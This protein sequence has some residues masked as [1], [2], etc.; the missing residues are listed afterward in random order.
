MLR[1]YNIL[2]HRNA[3][4]LCVVLS[5]RRTFEG[6]TKAICPFG[7]LFAKLNAQTFFH[8]NNIIMITNPSVEAFNELLQGAEPIVVDFNATWCGPCR[9][10]APIFD[11]LDKE[12]AGRAQFVSVD[13]DECEEL[14]MKYMVRN[15]P[16]ILFIKNGEVVSKQVGA[17]AK[18]VF[19]EKVE[20]LF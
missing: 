7:T 4:F 16:T 5:L 17:A 1:T 9:M 11:E 20:A 18:P 15:I 13:V 10:V 14:A 3:L 6:R 2:P 19:V 12:Y 8:Q